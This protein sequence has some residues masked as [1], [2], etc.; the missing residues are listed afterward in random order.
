[1]IFNKNSS[2]ARTTTLFIVLGLVL[3]V[4]GFRFD[5][6]ILPWIHQTG[7][8]NFDGENAC[9]GNQ[10][11]NDDSWAKRGFQTPPRGDKLWIESWQDY[12]I[13]VGY[14]SVSYSSD[15]RSATVNVKTRVNPKYSSAELKYFFNGE[16]RSSA[17]WS[18]SSPAGVLDIKVEAWQDGSKIASLQL[19]KIDF[20]WNHPQV[21]TAS[22]FK[23]GQKGVIV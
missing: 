16:S 12:N 1:M 20:I 13:L 14:P 15:K 2:R 9:R 5:K 8:S 6:N 3:C 21:N 22:N 23:N 17:T 7:C 11:Q 19:E 10:T 4:S 18:A